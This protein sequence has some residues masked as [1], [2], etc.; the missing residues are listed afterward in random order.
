MPFKRM[1]G[2][3]AFL[4]TAA[5]WSP[6]AW[7][8]TCEEAYSYCYHLAS[9]ETDERARDAKQNDCDWE[10]WVCTSQP[11]ASPV[12]PLAEEER[13]SSARACGTGAAGLKG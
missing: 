5:A 10:Y 1:C 4:V 2:F 3:V 6:S 7:A 11:T 13:S 8:G 9:L 12:A